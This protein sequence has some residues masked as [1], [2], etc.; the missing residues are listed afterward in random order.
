MFDQGREWAY[1]AIRDHW[2]PNGLSRWSEAVLAR[3]SALNGQFLE[4]LPFSEVKA[5]ARSISKWTWRNITPQGRQE[6]IQRTHTPERQA[7]RGRKGGL[8]STN[9]GDAGVASGQARRVS[10]EQ[11]R[12]TAR[13][14]RAQG[15]TQR[16]IAEALGVTQQ[17]ISKWLHN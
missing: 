11:E 5:T 14:M 16:A 6:L 1:S 8:A 12:A 17:A 9:Q 7:E 4:P 3:L 2:A 13:L 15:M 10:R